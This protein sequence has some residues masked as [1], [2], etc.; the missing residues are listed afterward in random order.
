MSSPIAVGEA[1]QDKNKAVAIFLDEI[2]YLSKEE[3]SALIM[4]MHRMQQRQLPI[5]LLG[6]GLKVLTTLAGESK[7]YAERLFM[8]PEI[9]ALADADARKALHDPIERAGAG[10]NCRCRGRSDVGTQAGCGVA[11]HQSRRRESFRCSN[12]NTSSR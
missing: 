11:P 5:V 3:L 12:R 9:G 2:Q 6:A 4:A 7:S 8:F 1:A 10:R